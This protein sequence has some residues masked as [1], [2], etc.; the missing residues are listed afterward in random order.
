MFLYLQK[1]LIILYINLYE[2]S[3]QGEESVEV[4]RIGGWDHVDKVGKSIA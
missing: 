3:T 4:R 1:C 2:E